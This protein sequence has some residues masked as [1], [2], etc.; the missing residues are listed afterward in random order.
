ML[1][2]LKKIE[3]FVALAMTEAGKYIY[4]HLHLFLPLLNV[5]SLNIKKWQQR[6]ALVAQRFGAA[7]G[8]GCDPGDPGSSLTLGSLRG[9]CFSLCLCLC[10]SLCVSLNKK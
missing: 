4:L 1:K 5:F 10:L 8:L 9:A 3:M 6:A 7:L 2:T